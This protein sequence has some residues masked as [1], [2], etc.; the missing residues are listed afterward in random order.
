M[1]IWVCRAKLS[2]VTEHR[3]HYFDILLYG[4]VSLE[5]SRPKEISN[6]KAKL[7]YFGSLEVRGPFCLNKDKCDIKVAVYCQQVCDSIDICDKVI[8]HNYS[9]GINARII[10]ILAHNKITRIKCRFAIMATHREPR[11]KMLKPILLRK[12]LA[13]EFSTKLVQQRF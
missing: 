13:R 7:A 4:F 11:S 10:S 1:T 8:V 3:I 9:N 6:S 12:G 2:A 5:L